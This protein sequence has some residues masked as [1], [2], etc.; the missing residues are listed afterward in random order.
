[1]PEEAY[2]GFWIVD[3]HQVVVSEETEISSKY[4]RI[5][6]GRYVR[7]RGER[8]GNLFFADKVEMEESKIHPSNV[9]LNGYKFYGTVEVLPD[10][11]KDLY[12][13]WQ[14]AG[15][16]VRVDSA[17]EI[18][19]RYGR[20]EIGAYAEVECSYIDDMLTSYKIR[21]IDRGG[22]YKYD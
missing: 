14:I 13:I 20:A 1:M 21:I 18:D 17:T 5:T 8:S 6:A 16:K 7:I 2:N 15:R 4:G 11:E 22:G 19:M 10:S 9:Y 12:G 3:D